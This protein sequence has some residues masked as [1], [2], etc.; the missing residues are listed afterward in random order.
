MVKSSRPR[1]AKGA[2]TAAGAGQSAAVETA[3][4]AA[5]AEKAAAPAEAERRINWAA[6]KRRY[7]HDRRM[8]YPEIA[9]HYGLEAQFLRDVAR[10]MHWRRPST[11]SKGKPRP[12]PP[13]TLMER[14]IMLIDGRVTQLEMALRSDHLPPASEV[15]RQSSELTR[16][17]RGL[18]QT[19]PALVGVATT[20]TGA[21]D[22]DQDRWRRELIE[23]IRALKSRVATH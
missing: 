19:K 9:K 20:T 22:D 15:D 18:G 3:Q 23:R 16:L 6:V 4:T 11:R 10:S 12:K 17:I 14:I 8:T 21:A 2:D 13:E 5:G 7:Q 1:A